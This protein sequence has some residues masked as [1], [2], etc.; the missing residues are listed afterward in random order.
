MLATI[1]LA[2]QHGW[3]GTWIG[4]T[5]GMVAAD[6]LAILVGRLLGKR[7]P[8]RAIRYGAATLFAVFGLWLIADAA[9]QLG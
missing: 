2:T 1:T 8:E 5:V 4:S 3:T 6:A 7:L 9:G